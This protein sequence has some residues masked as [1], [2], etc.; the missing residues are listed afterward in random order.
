[1]SEDNKEKI[2]AVVVTYNR[3]QLLSE[4]LHSLLE[5]SYPL[6]AIYI[7]DNAS[8]DG[9]PEYL[10]EKGFIDKQ[11]FSEKEPTKFLKTIPLPSFQAKTVEIHYV[12][13]HENIGGAGGFYEGV[14]RGYE[15]GYDWLWLMD[16]DCRSA[17]NCLENLLKQKSKDTVLGPMVL[18]VKEKP[19]WFE[20]KVIKGK[21]QTDSL[22]FN[23]FFIHRMLIKKIGYPIREFFIYCDDKEYSFRATS[24]G[25]NLFVVRDAFIYHPEFA[26][27]TRKFIVFQKV[28]LYG[29]II[30][31]DRLYYYIRNELLVLFLYWKFTTVF[32]LIRESIYFTFF[33]KIKFYY[34]KTLPCA[35]Y[36][37]IKLYGKIMNNNEYRK[38]GYD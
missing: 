31:R 5:Q 34:L 13:M 12:R 38:K 19:V 22:A 16:D 18:N 10:M 35:V 37:A 15:T 26:S 32:K 4:C 8:T 2:A 7:I 25:Y 27:I 23:G 29:V 14:K 11:L 1:M 20:E 30:R 3:K 9:T 24:R 36:D 28:I 21:Q 17:K 33:S 6:D